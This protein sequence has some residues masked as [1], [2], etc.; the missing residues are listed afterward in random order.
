MNTSYTVMAFTLN[1]LNVVLT[2]LYNIC[3]ISQPIKKQGVTFQ[4]ILN[5]VSRAE[6]LCLI[7]NYFTGINVFKLM[8]FNFLYYLKFFGCY[9][10][11]VIFHYINLFFYVTSA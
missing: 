11:V 8:Y 7:L 3:S 9:H 4:N 5:T 10:V 1:F 2:H 6:Y